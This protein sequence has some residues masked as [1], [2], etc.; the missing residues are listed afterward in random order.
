MSD[1]IS[2]DEVAYLAALDEQE[3]TA[4]A[5][6]QATRNSYNAHLGKKYS[7]TQGDQIKPDGAIIRKPAQTEK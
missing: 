3:R 1:T 5:A 7:L 6:L 2:A 4:I